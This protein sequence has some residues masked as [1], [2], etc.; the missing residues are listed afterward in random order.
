[1]PDGLPAS[2]S[3]GSFKIEVKKDNENITVTCTAYSD[4]NASDGKELKW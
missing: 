3:N 2:K 4:T 1:M